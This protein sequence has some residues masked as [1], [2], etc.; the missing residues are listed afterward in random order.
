MSINHPLGIVR[1]SAD[2][3]FD[4][5]L[6]V[7]NEKVYFGGPLCTSADKLANDVYVKTADIGDIAVFGLAGAYGLTMSN[8]EF[9]SHARPEEVVLDSKEFDS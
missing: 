4:R 3:I 1:T 5:Q 8:Q 7:E 2:K 9:L 6:S